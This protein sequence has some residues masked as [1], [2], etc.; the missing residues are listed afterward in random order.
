MEKRIGRDGRAAVLDGAMGTEL[1]RRGCDVDDPLWSAR[2]LRTDPDAVAAVHRDYAAAGADILT[3]ASYQASLPGLRQAGLSLQESEDLLRLSWTLASSAAAPSGA[4][5]AGDVGPYGAFLADGS[6]YRGD[7]RL[8]DAAFADFHRD[9]I[10]ILHEA[11]A[12]LFAVETMPRLDEALVCSDLLEREGCDY[13]VSFTFRD[14]GHL[15]CGETARQ[16]V[17]ELRGRPHLAAVGVNCLPPERAADVLRTLRAETDLPLCC[18]P[19]S[20][21]RYD[22]VRKSWRGGGKPL[23]DYVPL[24]L[25]L[26]VQLVGGCCRTRPRDIAAIA[27]VVKGD[28]AAPPQP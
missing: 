28:A 12:S 17:K 5:A 27:R 18:Y 22:P 21:E 4:E 1:E 23:A 24:W 11:G 7:Y 25:S 19:N 15:S 8:T 9:R 20:G 10:R 16:A 26:G 2:V 3:C 14:A 6:E 13:W